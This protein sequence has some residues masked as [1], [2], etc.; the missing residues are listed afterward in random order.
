MQVRKSDMSTYFEDLAAVRPTIMLLIPRLANMR[1][2]K[3]VGELEQAPE[4]D[5]D[6]KA[7]YKQACSPEFLLGTA[8]CFI[9]GVFCDLARPFASAANPYVDSRQ[10]CGGDFMLVVATLVFREPQS[11]KQLMALQV[12][13]GRWVNA[14]EVVPAGSGIFMLALCGRVASLAGRRSRALRGR[15]ETMRKFREEDVGGRLVYSLTG[16]SPI[17]PEVLVF[18]RGALQAPHLRG[19]RL[20]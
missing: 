7:A 5:D 11:S 6:A 2:D 3:L 18:L 10:G 1:Y 4:G 19:L 20:H 8:H 15:Q 13:K 12:M 9:W 17:A 16:S 14:K